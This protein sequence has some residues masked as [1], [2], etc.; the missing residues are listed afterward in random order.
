MSLRPAKAAIPSDRRIFSNGKGL[1]MTETTIS[2]AFADPTWRSA[3]DRYLAEHAHGMNGYMISR[4]RLASVARMNQMSDA[5]LAALG[6]SR[7]GIPAFVFEDLLP[8]WL[9]A[10]RRA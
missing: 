9:A 5:E 10:L 7:D 3:L 1:T 8:E 6:L 4:M 2:I